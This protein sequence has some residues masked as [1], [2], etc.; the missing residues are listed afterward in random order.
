MSPNSSPTSIVNELAT[1]LAPATA[2]GPTVL[3]GEE[4]EMVA[5][6]GGAS[7]GVLRTV[8]GAAVATVEH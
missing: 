5:A 7:G 2:G 6:A 8:V 1:N 3:T 4:A